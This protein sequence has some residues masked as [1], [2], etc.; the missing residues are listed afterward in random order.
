M[1]LNVAE[2]HEEMIGRQFEDIKLQL[3][4]NRMQVLTKFHDRWMVELI[5]LVLSSLFS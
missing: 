4:A 1:E 2:K 3:L 5:F